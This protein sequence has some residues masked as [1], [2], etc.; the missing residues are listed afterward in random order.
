MPIGVPP[1]E[2]VY[3]FQ[4]APAERVPVNER[5]DDPAEHKKVGEAFNDNGAE[6]KT[7]TII[8]TL[9]QLEKH[10]LFSARTK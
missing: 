1:H 6:G 7:F 8:E 9:A 4:T 10:P 5:V 2:P 3:H